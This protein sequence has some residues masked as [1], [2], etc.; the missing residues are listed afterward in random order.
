MIQEG[1]DRGD[2][3]E[4]SDVRPCWR[5]RRTNNVGGQFEFQAE[6]QPDSEPSPYGPPPARRVTADK[7]RD[8]ANERLDRR[9]YNHQGCRRLD[10]QGTVAAQ[11]TDYFFHNPT[12]QPHAAPDMASSGADM[13]WDLYFVFEG[14]T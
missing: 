3:G 9:I 1:S 13:I 2:C 12:T 7:G 8:K 5:D 14:L 6:Q 10:T 4:L 11:A